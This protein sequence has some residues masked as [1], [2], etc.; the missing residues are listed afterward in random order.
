LTETMHIENVSDM[1]IQLP[2]DDTYYVEVIK[3]DELDV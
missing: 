3:D 1:T 2:S